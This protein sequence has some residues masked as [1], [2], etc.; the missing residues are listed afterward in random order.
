[1]LKTRTQGIFN[2][3]FWFPAKG[4]NCY[5]LIPFQLNEGQF[6]KIRV[7]LHGLSRSF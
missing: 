5:A 3:P 1:M 4:V 2:G 6:L 7:N